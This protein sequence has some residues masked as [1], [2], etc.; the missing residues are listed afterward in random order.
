V[1]EWETEGVTRAAI[2]VAKAANAFMKDC[3]ARRLAR[4]TIKLH[5]ILLSKTL[6]PWAQAKH[7]HFLSPFDVDNLRAFL[8]VCDRV[9][10]DRGESRAHAQ[11]GEGS[12]E[13]RAAGP[14]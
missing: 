11:A 9:R 14:S 7:I 4:G 12:A 5:R 1:R 8:P 3:D 13:R 2:E 10:L 6:V